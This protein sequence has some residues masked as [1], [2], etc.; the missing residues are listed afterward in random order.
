MPPIIKVK[1]NKKQLPKLPAKSAKVRRV[2]L[3]QSFAK[4]NCYSLFFYTEQGKLKAAYQTH[5][6]SIVDL[7][8]VI[9][10]YIKDNAIPADSLY[11]YNSK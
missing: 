2:V 9:M 7:G 5:N 11:F 6:G 10:N 1:L 4:D 8:K 3:R